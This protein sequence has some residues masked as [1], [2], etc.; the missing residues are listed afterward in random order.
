MSQWG[1]RKAKVVLG[2]LQG[3]GWRIKR[4]T[5]SHKVLERAGWPDYV[6][7]ST[8]GLRSARTCSPASPATPVSSRRT[9][10]PRTIIR[11]KGSEIRRG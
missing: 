11:F 6:F 5:G 3:I 4:Q 10:D 1:A 2:A 7:V 9:C 8:M